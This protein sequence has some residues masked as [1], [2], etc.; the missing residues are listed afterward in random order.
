MGQASN[1]TNSYCTGAPNSIV[2]VRAIYPLPVYLDI[3]SMAS[4]SLKNSGAT[5][6]S[7][8]QDGQTSFKSADGVAGR[9]RMLMGI[10]SFRNEPFPGSAGAVC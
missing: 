6:A 1:P 10:A 2:V 9:K 4:S 5:G 7:T 3:L 8:N